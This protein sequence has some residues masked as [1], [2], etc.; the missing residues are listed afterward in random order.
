VALKEAV[1]EV[2]VVPVVEVPVTPVVGL[3]VVPVPVVEEPEVVGALE[4]LYSS[5]R[6]PAPQYSNALPGHTKEQSVKA[7]GTDP[8]LRALP[9]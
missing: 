8:A 5:K 6:L 3:V 1:V 7:A 2:L 9:Q 4:S